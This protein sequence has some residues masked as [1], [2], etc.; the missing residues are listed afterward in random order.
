MNRTRH[1]PGRKSIKC[2]NCG[3]SS[4]EFRKSGFLG[5]A[6]CYEKFA[7]SLPEILKRIHG[8][9]RHKGKVPCNADKAVKAKRLEHLRKELDACLRDERFEN[10]ARLRDRMK[11]LES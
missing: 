2:S 7:D 6:R 10:A 8:S 1:A 9:V 3:V 4:A 11:R 5:C